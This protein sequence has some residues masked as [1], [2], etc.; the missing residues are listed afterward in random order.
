MITLVLYYPLALILSTVQKQYLATSAF[1]FLI[2]VSFI[3]NYTLVQKE[4]PWSLVIMC[5]EP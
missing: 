1:L 5:I 2:T 3:S 4:I